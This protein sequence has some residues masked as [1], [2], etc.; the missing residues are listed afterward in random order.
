MSDFSIEL[1]LDMDSLRSIFGQHDSYIAK[2]EKQLHVTVVNRDGSAKIIGEE[3]NAQRA[4][5]LI[6][7]LARSIH[8]GTDLE[9]QRV[10]YVL[11][12]AQEEENVSL[13]DMEFTRTAGSDGHN[14]C[15]IFSLR[16]SKGISVDELLTR[17]TRIDGVVSVQEL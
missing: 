13:Q 12:L 14:P 16:F 9:E 7:E 15:A 17:V 3:R 8:R 4:A 11:Q 10:D 5:E 2:I 6:E 1:D